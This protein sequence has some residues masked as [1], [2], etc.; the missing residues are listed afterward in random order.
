MAT[1]SGCKRQCVTVTIVWLQFDGLV[2][3]RSFLLRVM[4]KKAA[5]CWMNGCVPLNRAAVR[6]EGIDRYLWCVCIS[7]CVVSHTG[8]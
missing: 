4:E 6:E 1:G 7:V 2:R 5:G 3:G 8:V